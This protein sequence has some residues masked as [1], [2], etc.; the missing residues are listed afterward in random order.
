M[1]RNKIVAL[2]AQFYYIVSIVIVMVVVGTSLGILIQI[3]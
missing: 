1:V 3:M 2:E